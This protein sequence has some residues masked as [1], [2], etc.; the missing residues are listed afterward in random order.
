M[1]LIYNKKVHFEY[2]IIEKYEAGIE[3]FGTEVKSCRLK[4]LSIA[5]GYI[6][7]EGGEAYLKQVNIAQYEQGNRNNHDP[8]RKR[9]LLLHKREIRKLKVAVEAKGMTVVPLSVYLK[10][11]LIKVGIALCKGK[12][13][14]DKRQTIKSRQDDIK[15][16]RIMKNR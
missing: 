6:S 13:T 5:E 14:H 3:L 15:I 11:G 12:D 8:V 1:D 9:R 10:N 4:K 16:Q 7:L 2:Q